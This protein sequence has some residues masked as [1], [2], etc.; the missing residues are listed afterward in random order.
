MQVSDKLLEMID[1]LPE[2]LQEEGTIGRDLIDTII[3]E[4]HKDGLRVGIRVYAW[5]KDGV[6]YVG[7]TGKTLE[8]ALEE[9]NKDAEA[10][11]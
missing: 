6:Q 3:D 10:L 2:E 11:L 1:K 4:A 9:A 5:W 8:E 7:S